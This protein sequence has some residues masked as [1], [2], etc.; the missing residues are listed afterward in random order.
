MQLNGHYEVQG[1]AEA[2][3]HTGKT[4]I[5][6]PYEGRNVFIAECKFWGGPKLFTETIDSDYVWL[7]SAGRKSSIQKR[8]LSCEQVHLLQY[9]IRR[10][11]VCGMLFEL[12]E[13]RKSLCELLGRFRVLL[14]RLLFGLDGSI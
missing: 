1:V 13:K 4:D 8:Y 7:G 12:W 9:Q 6:L 10:A 11:S 5:L 2:F 14:R 3:N